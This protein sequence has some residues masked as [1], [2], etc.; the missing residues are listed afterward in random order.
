MVPQG[1]DR[2]NDQS[3]QVHQHSQR[4]AACQNFS[5]PRQKAQ[6]AADCQAY[7]EDGE[8]ETNA[9]DGYA[10]LEPVVQSQMLLFVVQ[11]NEDDARHKGLQDLEEPRDRGQK[12]ADRTSFSPG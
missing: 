8:N 6:E 10:P 4:I 7:D 1:V 3:C 12:A 5:K 2:P 9:V 11:A